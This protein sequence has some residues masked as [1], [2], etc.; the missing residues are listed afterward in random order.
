[1]AHENVASKNK[2]TQRLVTFIIVMGK[3]TK[4]L[5]AAK[6]LKLT[7][8]LVTVLSMSLSAIAYAFWLGP[9]FS[10]GLVAMIF[11]H[12]MGHVIALKLRGYPS[13]A[14]V[15]IPF[16]GAVIF[17]P[18]M[19]N[20]DDEA[21]V[22]IGGPVLGSLAA[23][24]TLLV[25]YIMPDKT[26]DAAAILL[27]VSYVGMFIN[28]FNMVPIRPLDGGR[29]TQA[30]GPWFK[31]I[32]VAA[33]CVLSAFW[34]EPAVLYIWVLV[35]PE[36]T[37]LPLRMRAGLSVSMWGTM[38]ILMLAGFSSQPF[39]IDMVDIVFAGTFSIMI[40]AQ[41]YRQIDFSEDD[42][43]RPELEPKARLVW[44]VRYLILFAIL[45]TLIVYQ[46]SLLPPL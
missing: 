24:G 6:L 5:K 34:R 27:V 13:S 30:V 43:S 41:A 25:W 2:K 31:Y 7:A 22:G 4:L 15:F 20:R 44:L 38:V 32:G 3:M 10:I 19:N 12:E 42:N 14:P 37:I 11:L 8:P 17:A 45:T 39:W 28:L 33:L 1:M 46:A 9:W 16:L 36:I 40:C 23:L 26:S 18:S 21:F 29:I 35:M